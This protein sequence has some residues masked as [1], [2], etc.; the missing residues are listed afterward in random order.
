MTLPQP[1]P[2]HRRSHWLA[3]LLALALLGCSAAPG[4][5]LSWR[6]SWT[7]LAVD[8][9]GMWI[10][11]ELSRGNTGLLRGQGDLSVTVFPHKESAVLLQ[12]RA[13]PQTV[14]FQTELGQ[15]HLA[16]DRLERTTDGWTLQVREGR[17]ALD[18]TLRL[19]PWVDELPP[20]TLV[21]GKRQWIAG[22][23]VPFGEVSGAWRAGEQGGLVRG[24]GML[25]R[26]SSDTLPGAKPDHGTLVLLGTQ[27]A[28]AVQRAGDGSLAWCAGPEG[29]VASRDVVIE[30][31]RR[32][33][34]VSLGTGQRATLHLGPRAV[35]REPWSH[36]LGFERLLARMLDRLPLRTYQRGQAEIEADGERWPAKALMV[37]GDPPKTRRQLRRERAGE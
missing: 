5:K 23:P 27:R 19:V 7:L 11:A 30:R 17:E 26:S 12:R 22:A 25:L 32:D 36:L 6:E 31:S 20:A 14:S 37:H 34:T 3:P 18:A 10:E 4:D 15:I 16:Q 24:H 21:E 9:G 8:E 35:V 13:A 33:I 28:L 2:R 29:V 1:S